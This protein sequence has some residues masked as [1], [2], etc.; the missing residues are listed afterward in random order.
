[1]KHMERAKILHEN[2]HKLQ[3]QVFQWELANPEL[4]KNSPFYELR[5]PFHEKQLRGEKLDPPTFLE[6]LWIVQI[7]MGDGGTVFGRNFKKYLCRIT[8][9]SKQ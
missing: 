5:K 4:F 7:K 9:K 3:E 2:F 8:R 1:M 6:C